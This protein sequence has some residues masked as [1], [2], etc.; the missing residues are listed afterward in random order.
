MPDTPDDPLLGLRRVI[1]D[2]GS[3]DPD[4]DPFLPN[5]KL[6]SIFAEMLKIRR[7][8][9]R[10]LGKQRQGK[11]GFFGT[12]TG[13]EATPIATAFATR[14]TDWVFPALR[15]SSIMMQS[16]GVVPSS[17]RTAW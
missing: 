2:D 6:L 14:P 4:T 11:V 16:F 13:Q 15:E 1:R 12:I 8:D 10:M 9:E 5:E 17:S 7:I 3:A